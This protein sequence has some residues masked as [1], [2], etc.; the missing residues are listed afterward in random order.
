MAHRKLW[1]VLS[2][3]LVML[4]EYASRGGG[5]GSVFF[6]APDPAGPET[7]VGYQ[8]GTFRLHFR[9]LGS[10]WCSMHGGGAGPIV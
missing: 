2:V 4:Q 6:I 8:R 10:M 7:R 3:C 1:K 9:P 5:G